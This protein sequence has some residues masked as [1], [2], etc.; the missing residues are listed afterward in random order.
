MSV[1][2]LKAMAER[3]ARTFAQSLLATLTVSGAVPDDVLSV[4][5][6]QALSVAAMATIMSVLMSIGSA[7]LAGDPDSPSLVAGDK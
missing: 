1:Q 3:A 4:G 6:K 2:F 5:W 7:R